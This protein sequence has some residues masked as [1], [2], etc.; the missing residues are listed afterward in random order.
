VAFFCEKYQER[1]GIMKKGLWI[2]GVVFSMVLSTGI[3]WA[4]FGMVVPSDQMV[5]QGEDTK[6]TL[7][8]LFWHPMERVGMELVKPA[9]FAVVANG[10]EQDLMESLQS[11]KTQGHQTWTAT[12]KVTRPG[13]YVFYMEPTPYWE[14]AEDCFIVHY[15]KAVVTA[16]G[17][18]EGWDEE[19]GL[20]TEI[21]PLSK[22]YGLYAGNVFQGIVK[23]DGKPVP[24]A[25]VEVEYYNED[26]SIHAP[27]DYM[28]T[29]TVKADGN[30]VFTYAVPKAG[31]WGFAALN[32]SD[33]KKK[34]QG[35][36]KDIELGA[37][38]W[39]QFH[40]MK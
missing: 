24:Y 1:K 8:L 32:T 21:V 33:E 23:L 22:P 35:E 36:D 2:V 3:A 5:M 9:K 39:V 28:V 12:Y 40:D 7:D 17:D 37:V 19:I 16:F 18:D 27:T 10:Q 14:P 13:V 31:W 38:I 11:K 6:V 15:T 26:G 30:G 20:K 29:Q 34:H 25:E 4:H